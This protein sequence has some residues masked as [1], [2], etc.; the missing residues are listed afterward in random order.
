L[1]RALKRAH[2]SDASHHAADSQS[3]LALTY[4]APNIF[5]HTWKT[6]LSSCRW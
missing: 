5:F 3:Q 6:V 1:R 4:L 2:W